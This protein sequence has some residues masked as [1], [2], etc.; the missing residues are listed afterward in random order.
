MMLPGHLLVASAG[1]LVIKAP[2]LTGWDAIDATMLL[3]WSLVL[4]GSVL[5]DI[6]H[7]K[8]FI[9]RR[10]PVIS[11]PLRLILGHR[12]QRFSL[13]PRGLTHSLLAIVAL[14]VLNQSVGNPWLNWLIVG[15]ALH[16]V[17]DFL[18]P[19]G[20]P[21]FWPLGRDIRAPLVANTNSM[22]EWVLSI[23]AFAG[24]VVYAF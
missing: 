7:P 10:F 23:G 4:V 6:D 12:G 5:P 18:T 19:S 14:L 8:S 3:Q 21:L 16:L 9:G 13:L 22:G 20:I 15:Y 11:W 1:V 2:Y 17:G 24:A